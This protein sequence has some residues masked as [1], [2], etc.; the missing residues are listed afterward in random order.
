MHDPYVEF[1]NLRAGGLRELHGYDNQ[2]QVRAQ[3]L[4]IGPVRRWAG[5]HDALPTSEFLFHRVR[6]LLQT[7]RERERRSPLRAPGAHCHVSL[8]RRGAGGNRPQ[9][10]TFDRI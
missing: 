3:G 1:L 8:P 9:A 7:W 10:V 6:Y 2:A 5:T 4:H